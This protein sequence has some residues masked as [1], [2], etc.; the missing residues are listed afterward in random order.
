MKQII[1]QYIIQFG[2]NKK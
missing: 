2:L 1:F